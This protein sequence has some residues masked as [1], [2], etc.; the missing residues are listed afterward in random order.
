MTEVMQNIQ[1]VLTEVENFN[2]SSKEELENF[3]LKFL[4]KKGMLADIFSEMKNIAAEERKEFG[5]QVNEL[6]NKVEEKF[7]SLQEV[8][9]QDSDKGTGKK[10]DLT[11][12]A[13][14]YALGARH[15]I[16]R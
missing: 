2:A 3:R 11:L 10:I 7:H 15:P 6:K 5:R 4:S 1:D 14:S 9:E 12:P 8:F 13:E 16:S